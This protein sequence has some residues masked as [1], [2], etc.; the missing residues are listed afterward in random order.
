M[1]KKRVSLAISA[2]LLAALS[3]AACGSSEP[4]A[5][6]KSGIETVKPGVLTV[7][8]ADF[9]YAGFI[10]G[11]DPTAP[12][13]GYFVDLTEKIGKELGLKVEYNKIDFTAMIGGQ[14][15]NY[16]ISADTFSILPERVEKFDMTIP[17]WSDHIAI[18]TK[19]GVDASTADKIRDLKLGSCGACDTSQY[20]NKVIKPNVKPLGF[21]EDQQKYDAVMDGRIDGALGNLPSVLAKMQTPKYAGMQAACQ[22]PEESQYAWILN[23]GAAVFPKVQELLKKYQADGTLKAMQDKNVLPTLGGVDPASVPTCPSFS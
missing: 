5:E 13:G 11:S 7:V 20:I 3:T 4:V 19:K 9:P 2:V 8:F 10:D 22:L 1:I 18:A 12:T 17:I 6:N 16:D 15:K 21:D 14:A 23:K